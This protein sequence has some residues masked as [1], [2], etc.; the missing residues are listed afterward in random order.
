MNSKLWVCHSRHEVEGKQMALPLLQ[1]LLRMSGDDMRILMITE[2]Y[3]NEV[4]PM[5]NNE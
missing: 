1:R 5:T 2:A 4:L 3:R